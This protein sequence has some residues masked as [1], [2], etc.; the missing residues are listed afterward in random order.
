ML[1]SPAPPTLKPSQQPRRGLRRA[2]D[3]SA[4]CAAPEAA[5]LSFVRVGFSVRACVG[6]GDSL[7]IVG[8]HAALGE[9]VRTA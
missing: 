5:E 6:F 8:S 7:A 2:H 3:T 4:A 1:L 9:W